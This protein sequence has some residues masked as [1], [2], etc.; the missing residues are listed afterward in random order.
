MYTRLNIEYPMGGPGPEVIALYVA[1][2]NVIYPQRE[3]GDF[4]GPLKRLP[5]EVICALRDALNLDEDDFGFI[6]GTSG[7]LIRMWEAGVTDDRLATE[8][9]MLLEFIQVRYGARFG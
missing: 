5:R 1:L 2:K 7:D 8:E 6:L 9:S 3:D 4:R